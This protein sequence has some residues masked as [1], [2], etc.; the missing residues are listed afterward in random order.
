MSCSLGVKGRP[1]EHG[2]RR[3]FG[4]LRASLEIVPDSLVCLLAG[5]GC[6]AWS[7]KVIASS[8][9]YFV[10]LTF[11]R[12]VSPNSKIFADRSKYFPFDYWTF[13]FLD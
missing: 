10:I 2:N 4:K 1:R 9:Y 6:I 3:L 12:Y 8:L 7:L 11:P 13:D 5:T